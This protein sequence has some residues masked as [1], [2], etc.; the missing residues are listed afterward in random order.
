M[1]T[2]TKL[3]LILKQTPGLRV[4]PSFISER[5]YPIAISFI[6]CIVYRIAVLSRDRTRAPC[7][8][9]TE[10]KPLDH[11]GSTLLPVIV[12]KSSLQEERIPEGQESN[13]CPGSLL[14]SPISDLKQ[15]TPRK[16]KAS[17][18]F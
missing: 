2:V 6:F 16:R 5:A 4:F 13:V 12:I 18:L 8:A 15:K 1:Y 7:T 14:G 3:P 10:S 11:Q 9:S 17:L